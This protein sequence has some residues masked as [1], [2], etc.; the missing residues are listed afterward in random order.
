MTFNDLN[1]TAPI[2]NALDDMGFVHPTTI[3]QKVF[4]VMMSG[5][6]V[7]GI[8]QTGTGKTYAYLLPCLRQWKFS[9]DRFPRILIIVPTRE[10]VVQV[11]EEVKKLTAYM[12]LRVVGVYGGVNMKP[13]A[14]AVEEG[15]DMIVA[16]PGRLLDLIYDGSVRL[17]MVNR[18][19]IDEVDEMLNL[20]FRTQLNNIFDML[21]PKRQILLFSA[22]MTPDVELMVN[23]YFDLP[24]K[25]EAAPTGT[26]LANINQTAYQVPNFNTKVNL[27]EQL[28]TQNEDMSKVLVFVGTKAL[29]DDLYEHLQPKFEGVIGVIHSNKEQNHRFNT[30]NQFQAGVFRFIIAT[31]IIA[32]GLDISEVTHVVNFDIPEVPENYIHRIGRTGRADKK[33]IAI[34]F[35]TEKEKEYVDAIEQLMNY[36]IQILPLPT[37]LEIS[38]EL[39]DDEKP[40]GHLKEIKLKHPKMEDSGP[41]FHE[42]SLKNKKV[43]VKVR[44]T[45]VM[46]AKYGKPQK[47]APKK[48]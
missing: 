33:G 30:V 37:D 4:S 32:R 19:I 29:A 2:L 42:K 16:T 12:T 48:R 24:L 44:H 11:V 38:T 3:Q 14:A 18:F 7:C 9:K 36:Q 43:N 25:I 21:P 5:K 26:P 41:A 39:T 27:I 47:R 10:L 15:V 22:T 40:K 20:G 23:N 28:L 13:Q 34:S 1:L 6:D 46:K 31:D 35:I 8:A 45:D 17:K